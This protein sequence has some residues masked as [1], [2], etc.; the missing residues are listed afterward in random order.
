M[1]RMS[2]AIENRTYLLDENDNAFLGS[3]HT[4]ITV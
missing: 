2:D 4:I 3:F 1:G